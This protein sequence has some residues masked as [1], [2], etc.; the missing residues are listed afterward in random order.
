MDEEAETEAA[1]A[2]LGNDEILYKID[3]GRSTLE[4]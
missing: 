1:M 4:S 2:M 3:D